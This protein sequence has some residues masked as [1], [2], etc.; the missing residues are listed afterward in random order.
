MRWARLSAAATLA[1]I[2][3]LPAGWIAQRYLVRGLTL[4]AV[5]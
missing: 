3:V 5:K 4:G 2:P 1:A